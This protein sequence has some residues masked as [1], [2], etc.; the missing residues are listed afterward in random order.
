MQ[1]PLTKPQGYLMEID[2]VLDFT[3]IKQR[4]IQVRVL[5]RIGEGMYYNIINYFKT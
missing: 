1:H 3:T 2:R 4:R 5:K